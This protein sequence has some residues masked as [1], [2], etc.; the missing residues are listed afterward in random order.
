MHWPTYIST[1]PDLWT[2]QGKDKQ[3][4]YDHPQP[5]TLVGQ[6]VSDLYLRGSYGKI[7]ERLAG[8]GR[9]QSEKEQRKTQKQL[10]R[11]QGR[12]MAWLEGTARSRL[13]II[14]LPARK[15]NRIDTMNSMGSNATTGKW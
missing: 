9:M 6:R 15:G 12:D 13:W 8:F 14:D 5:S 7:V 3:P 4:D 11:L 2:A 1:T 10:T